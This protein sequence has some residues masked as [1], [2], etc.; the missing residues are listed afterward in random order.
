MY[1]CNVALSNGVVLGRLRS[2][3]DGGAVTRS[4]AIES[5]IQHSPSLFSIAAL[6]KTIVLLSQLS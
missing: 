4:G 1:F 5:R 6:T 2:G 3:N